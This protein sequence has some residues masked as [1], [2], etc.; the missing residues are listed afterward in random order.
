MIR[1][2]F[3]L[4]AFTAAPVLAHDSPQVETPQTDAATTDAQPDAAPAMSASDLA[5]IDAIAN[6]PSGSLK[7]EQIREV[8]KEF[9]ERLREE[10]PNDPPTKAVST[11]ISASFLPGAQAPS[12]TLHHGYVTSIDLVD[13][14]GQPWPAYSPTIG[15]EQAVQ[16]EGVLKEEKTDSSVV[17][18]K[19]GVRYANTNLI[20][21]LRGAPRPI[22]L[23]LRND[24]PKADA[25]VYDRITIIIEGRGPNASP[26]PLANA[27]VAP[28][29]DL[30]AV[31]LGQK[32][33]KTA[34]RGDVGLDQTTAWI[35]GDGKTMWVRT[36]LELISPAPLAQLQLGELRAY[37]SASLPRIVLR[38]SDGLL[39]TVNVREV[40][41][42]EQ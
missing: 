33:S 3:L 37:R 38:G 31:L 25:A 17:V 35:D 23:L 21:P 19:P 7:P 27:L 9:R 42:H 5:F 24:D 12:I 1:L 40:A 10:V 2:V 18:L 28:Q 4:A 6:M 41:I 36:T 29:D 22:T 15:D 32:P 13:S 11:L 26:A 14:T 39:E 16:I 8:K 34:Y 20:L 30:R